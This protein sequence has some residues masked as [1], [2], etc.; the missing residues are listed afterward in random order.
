MPDMEAKTE[1][2]PWF[3]PQ[4]RSKSPRPRTSGAL[5]NARIQNMLNTRDERIAELQQE[6]DSARER[7]AEL[8]R[9]LATAHAAN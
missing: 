9:E 7:I 8:E 2:P 1:Q 4:N 3:T 6:L 5:S